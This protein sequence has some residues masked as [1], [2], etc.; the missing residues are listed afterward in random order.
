LAAKLKEEQE[1][2][3]I[4]KDEGFAKRKELMELGVQLKKTFQV[5]ILNLIYYDEL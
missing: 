2:L 3:R 4:L 5:F 1:R